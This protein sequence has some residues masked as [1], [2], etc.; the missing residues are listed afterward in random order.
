MNFK[1]LTIKKEY[2]I[3]A[4]NIIK[5]FYLP[6]LEKSTLYQ[7]SVAYFTS[8]SLYE[9][10]YGITHLL[11]N[12]GQIQLIVSPVLSDEDLEAINKGYEAR[13]SIT[14]QALLRYL[15]EPRIILMNY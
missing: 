14:E 1:E 13:D 11:K 2:R 15:E 12:N 8:E 7:R 10:S 3:P 4:N 5:E 6:I 9:L